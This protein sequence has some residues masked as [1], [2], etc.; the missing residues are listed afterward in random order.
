MPKWKKGAR[1]FTVGV[2]YSDGRGYQSSIPL[3][4]MEILGKTDTIKFVISEEDNSVQLV[5]GKTYLTPMRTKH[6]DKK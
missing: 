5:S 4:I 2:N 1:E 3:P 6:L